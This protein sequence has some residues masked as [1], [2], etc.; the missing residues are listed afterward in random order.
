M[1]SRR[2]GGAPDFVPATPDGA[3]LL[4]RDVDVQ[5]PFGAAR[6]ISFRQRPTVLRC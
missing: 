6:R 5:G 1:F 2:S 3:S 4:R